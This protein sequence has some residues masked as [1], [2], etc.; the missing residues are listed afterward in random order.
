MS[1]MSKDANIIHYY[2]NGDKIDVL[3]AET[4]FNDT[5]HLLLNGGEG[6]LKHIKQIDYDNAYNVTHEQF[7]KTY[8]KKESF[9]NKLFANKA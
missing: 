4:F 9:W 3:D 2:K 6:N 5:V 1:V 7:Y 8:R